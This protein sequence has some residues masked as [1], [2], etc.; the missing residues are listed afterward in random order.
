ML[1]CLARKHLTAAIITELKQKKK[2]E[3]FSPSFYEATR[4]LHDHLLTGH[5]T[6]KGKGLNKPCAFD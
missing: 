3:E 5:P 6:R 1:V 4:K 2:D